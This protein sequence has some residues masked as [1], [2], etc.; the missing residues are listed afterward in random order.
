[1]KWWNARISIALV[2]LEKA[3][4]VMIVWKTHEAEGE[5]D[6]NIACGG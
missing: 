2:S 1:M 6:E 4:R 3:G 5:Y